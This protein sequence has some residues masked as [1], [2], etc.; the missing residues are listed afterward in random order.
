MFPEAMA[1]AAFTR[2]SSGDS[3]SLAINSGSCLDGPYEDRGHIGLSTWGVRS[4]EILSALKIRGGLE[5]S[6]QT[7]K[8]LT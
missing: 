5:Q 7:V 1:A 2:S 3:S 8:S 4:L 6:S